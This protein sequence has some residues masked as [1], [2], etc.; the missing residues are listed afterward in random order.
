MKIITLIIIGCMAGS[1]QAAS[2][3]FENFEPS[4]GVTTGSLD[5]QN[6]WAVDSGSGE[7]QTSV[8]QS[9]VQALEISSGSIS[10]GISTNGSALWMHFYARITEVPQLDPVVDSASTVAVFYVNTSQNLVVLSNGVPVELTTQMPINIWTRF[11]VYCDYV[12]GVWNLAMDGSHVASGL[13]LVSSNPAEQVMVSNPSAAY[14]FL[15]SL[16]IA[17]TEQVGE[18]PDSDADGIP[19]WWEQKN[20]GGVTNVVADNPSGNGDL[21]YEETYIAVLDPF[22]DDP[23]FAALENSEVVWTPKLSRLHDVEW[24]PNLESNFV[25]IASD[26]AWPVDRYFDT[27]HTNELTGFYRVKIHL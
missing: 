25:A 26:I 12:A 27:A 22:V 5:G 2:V 15:D 18:V 10:K 9:G 20:F 1:T 24:A 21:T 13:P 8:V 16:D 19:D 17:D 14:S 11:D 7:V 3:L 23:P 4:N 6:G